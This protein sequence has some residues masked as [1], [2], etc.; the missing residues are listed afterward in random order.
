MEKENPGKLVCWFG[1]RAS[2]AITTIKFG[3]VSTGAG[4]VEPVRLGFQRAYGCDSRSVFLND[5]T[6]GSISGTNDPAVALS[7]YWATVS[8]HPLT[9]LTPADSMQALAARYLNPRQVGR[10]V[11]SGS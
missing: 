9:L 2:D 11:S 5:H 4:W 1:G 10:V 3:W 8:G 7:I 6:A